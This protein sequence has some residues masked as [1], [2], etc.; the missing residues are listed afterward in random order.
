MTKTISAAALILLTAPALSAQGEFW[1]ELKAGHFGVGF[2]AVYQADPARSYDPDYPTPGR[3]AAKKARPIF[4]AIWYPAP[5]GEGKSMLHRDYLRAVTLDSGAPDLAQRLRI[6]TRDQAS[7]YMLGKE[8]E[9]LT[10]EDRARWDGLLST[11]VY[12]VLN[13][14][15]AEGKFPVILYHPGLGGTYEDNA[16]LCEFLASHGYIVIS[17]AYQS[18]DSSSLNIDGDLETSLA[19]LA[20]LLRF[21]AT[22]PFADPE[23]VAAIGHSYG[24]QAVIAWRALPNSTLDAVV[25]LDSNV[26]YVGLDAPQFPAIKAAVA[27]NPKSAVPVIFF[28]DRERHPH[29][30]TFTPYLKF[31]PHYEVDTPTL[32]HNAFVSQGAVVKDEPARRAYEAVCAVILQFL[33]AQVKADPAPIASD[34]LHVRTVPGAPPPPTGA[35]IARVFRAEGPTNQQ[36]LTAF[37]RNADFDAL[38]AA[39]A[40]LFDGDEKKQAVD[41][42]KQSTR[43]HPK[44]AAIQESL[45]EALQ[46]TGDPDAAQAAFDTALALL[47]G[48][49]TLSADQKETLQHSIEQSRKK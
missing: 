29:F 2:R 37:L 31:A 27:R 35:Q 36:A 25:F 48:D 18:A 19:D 10:T 33:N 42:L 8:Y 47:P 24:A 3:T 43:I 21:A 28:A 5:S 15:A 44:S 16:V 9:D 39:A 45:G 22:L 26:L 7:L 23:R 20:V 38:I 6:H 12:A 1:G 40:I 17:S 4:A 11:P 30:E 49:D 32:E 41:L 46:Q 34:L 13:A 14:P